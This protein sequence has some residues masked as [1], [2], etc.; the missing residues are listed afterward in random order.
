LWKNLFQAE[1]AFSR[2]SGSSEELS[3]EEVNLKGFGEVN[4]SNE[5]KPSDFEVFRM[6][7]VHSTCVLRIFQNQMTN[8]LQ[9]LQN[10]IV[11]ILKGALNYEPDLANICLGM[12]KLLSRF[13]PS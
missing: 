3:V 5:F 7:T 10:F 8:N 1:I 2:S 11:R 4:I 12:A 13:I 9:V 6:I